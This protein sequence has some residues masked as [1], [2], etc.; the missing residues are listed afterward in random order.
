MST[1]SNQKEIN[2]LNKILEESN[3]SLTSLNDLSSE[4]KL[5]Y[6]IKLM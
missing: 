4:Q 2:L 3:K 6:I 5:V 1:V